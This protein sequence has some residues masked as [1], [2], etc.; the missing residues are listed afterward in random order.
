MSEPSLH[1]D[2]SI[3][4]LLQRV[5][6]QQDAINNEAA[7]RMYAAIHRGERDIQL[8]EN[9]ADPLSDAEYAGEEH[10]RNLIRYVATFNP[11]AAFLMQDFFEDINGYKNLVVFAIVRMVRTLYTEDQFAATILPLLET[12]GN[13]IEL[14]S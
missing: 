12:R 9:I 5:S 1:I 11:T 14:T 13:W 6:A 2:P 8:L 4:E 3:V 7:V 10:Y